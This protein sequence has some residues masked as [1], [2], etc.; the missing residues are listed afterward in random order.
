LKQYNEADLIEQARQ[1][2]K[3]S[4]SELYQRHADV[5]YRYVYVR[6]QDAVLAEDL[7]AEVF[8]KA[9]EG[10]P[11]YQF[12]GAPFVAWLYRIARARTIDHWRQQQRRPESPLL[13]TLPSGDPQPEELVAGWTRWE[14][15]LEV[16]PQLTD[17]QQQAIVLRF[18]EEMSLEET[19]LT[20]NK[21]VGA[22]KALQHRA[23]AS[24]ARLLN[25]KTVHTS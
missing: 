14:A 25:V 19:A 15:V 22:V 13:D 20:M 11:G 2:D 9:L 7:T 21:T 1:G 4:I 10:L 18:V 5:V 12:T 3:G 23:L 17:E 8:L 16:L 24:L 6:V